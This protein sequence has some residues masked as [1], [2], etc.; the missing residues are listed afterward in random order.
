MK[1]Y[2]IIYLN[3]KKYENNKSVVLLIT[4]CKTF[5]LLIHNFLYDRYQKIISIRLALFLFTVELAAQNQKFV[6]QV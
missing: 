3:K 2:Y 6:T 1:T 5:F 4:F